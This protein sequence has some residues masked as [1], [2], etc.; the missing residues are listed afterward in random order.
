M[1]PLGIWQMREGETCYYYDY[2]QML[3]E[4]ELVSGHEKIVQVM[5]PLI[6]AELT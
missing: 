5:P 4:L 1:R 6:L 3:T 2:V